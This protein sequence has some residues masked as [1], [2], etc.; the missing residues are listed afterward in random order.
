MSCLV[1]KLRLKL[2]TSRSWGQI[3]YSD[4][5][6]HHMVGNGFKTY[7]IYGNES[8]KFFDLSKED[9]EDIQLIKNKI[10]SKLPKDG[11]RNLVVDYLSENEWN[12][13]R[14]CNSKGISAKSIFT[15]IK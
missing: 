7:C 11:K 12:F 4:E 9:L 3:H 14:T 6:I 15:S 1:E 8:I 5:L 10:T 2:A 13:I